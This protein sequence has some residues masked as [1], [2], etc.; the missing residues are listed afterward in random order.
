[1]FVYCVFYIL[2]V[3]FD[4]IGCLPH[5]W[6]SFLRS[7]V[8]NILHIHTY[9]VKRSGVKSNETE[10]FDV[11]EHAC[12]MPPVP[13]MAHGFMDIL[14]WMEKPVNQPTLF[15]ARTSSFFRPLFV[16]LSMHS[17][18]SSSGS[19]SIAPLDTYR[20]RL[21]FHNIQKLSIYYLNFHPLELYPF[22]FDFMRLVHRVH[23]LENLLKMIT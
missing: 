17:S 4:T 6:I 1:M 13:L 16:L 12:S 19:G 20:N 11:W 14:H 18:S 21:F 10:T 8:I 22:V 2:Y 15:C 3:L 23:G 9:D 7:I 5:A